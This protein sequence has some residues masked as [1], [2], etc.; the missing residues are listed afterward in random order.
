MKVF[1]LLCALI[2][3]FLS[4]AGI[5]SAFA[6]TFPDKPVKLVVPYQPGGATD[7]VARVLAQ[8]LSEKWKQPVII[9][10][11]PGAS[12]SLGAAFVAKSDPDGYTLLICDSSIYVVVPHLLTNF[13]YDP[14]KDLAPITIVA[15]QPPVL[16][17]RKSLPV[18]NTKE[19]LA[20][21]KAHP[22]ELTYGSF[23]VGTW[24]HVAMEEVSKIENLK[25]LHVPFRGG[26]EVLNE[27]LAERVDV[28][29]ATM[30]AVKQ[31]KELGSLKVLAT[32]TAKRL[33]SEPD[34]PTMSESGVPGYSLSVWFGL[35]APSGTSAAILDKIQQDVAQL[36]ADPQFRDKVLGTLA[37]EP[38]GET[39]QE[40]SNILNDE[41]DR[42]GKVIKQTGIFIAGPAGTAK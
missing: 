10:N 18:S 26:A 14:H 12:A 6:Q 33:S 7:T 23:G 31:Y 16:T 32:A 30:G 28:F 15:R 4:L 8:Q 21:I 29:F 9:L 40:F 34:L 24:A 2:F 38:G 5:G 22:G 37:L 36:N 35:A 11:R 42:W 19:L 39:R 27:M 20:Y 13:P 17:T 3:F 1:N 41:F 25:M